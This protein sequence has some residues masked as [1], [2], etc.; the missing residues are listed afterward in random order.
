MVRQQTGIPFKKGDC[1]IVE[2]YRPVALI[3]MASKCLE[4]YLLN[5][6]YEWVSSLIPDIQHGFRCVRSTV[7]QLLQYIDSLYKAT[8]TRDLVDSVY[9]DFSNAFDKI[10]HETLLNSSRSLLNS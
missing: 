5:A 4:K 9:L 10:G 1:P 3:D 6:L 8:H 7:T 2:N